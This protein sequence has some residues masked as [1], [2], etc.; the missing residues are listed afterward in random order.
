[1]KELK[2][3]PSFQPLNCS[4]ANSTM[5]ATIGAG[6]QDGELLD[7]LAKEHLTAVAGTN[8]VRI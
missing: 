4:S 7:Q 8:M 6:I 1:M 5:A 2:I 3:H